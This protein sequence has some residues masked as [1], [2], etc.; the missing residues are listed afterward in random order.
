MTLHRPRLTL[1]LGTVLLGCAAKQTSGGDAGT[2]PS[3]SVSP[4]TLT[5][6]VGAEQSFAATVAGLSNTAVTWSVEEA[7]GGIIS[8]EGVY[9]APGA[10]GT[11]HV[12]ATSVSDATQSATATVAVTNAQAISIVLLPTS[13]ALNPGGTQSFTTEVFGSTNQAVTW[14]VEEG[15]SGGGVT[16]A[17]VYTAPAGAGTF[18]V[19]ATSAKDPTKNAMAVVTV[20]TGTV[21]SVSVSPSSASLGPT[22][23]QAFT[24]TVT[25]TSNNAVTWTVAEGAAGG[26]VSASGLYTSPSAPGVY[27]V[28]ATSVADPSQLASGTIT[29]SALP[30]GA[31]VSGT[32]S[33][34]GTQA[35]RVYLGLFPTGCTS[36]QPVAGTSLAVPG[37]Y[38]LHVGQASGSFSL[39]AFIDTV[40]NQQ[41]AA[42]ADPAGSNTSVML[43]G[44]SLS[45]VNVTLTD[46][47]PS[48]PVA[49]GVPVGFFSNDAALLGWQAPSTPIDHVSVYWT[50]TTASTC[51]TATSQYGAPQTFPAPQQNNGP[52]VFL[53]GLTHGAM[54]CF[55]VAGVAGSLEGP[56]S[57]PLGPVAVTAPTGGSTVS[58]TVS[59]PGLVPSGPLYVAVVQQSATGIPTHLSFVD[60][61]SPSSPQAFTVP[62][63]PD[64]IYGL[65]AFIDMN[66]AGAMVPGV[67]GN[68]SMEYPPQVTVSGGNVSS[69]ML[70][71]P[72]G[73][74]TASAL[75]RHQVGKEADAGVGD[76]YGLQLSLG[77]NLRIP[78]TATLSGGPHLTSLLDVGLSPNGDP[79]SQFNTT[80]FLGP[81]SPSVG[82]TYVFQVTYSDA[83]AAVVSA[84]VSGVIGGVATLLTPPPGGAADS[85]TPTFSWE[86]PGGLSSSD[87]QEILIQPVTG[88]NTIWEVQALPVSKT[89]IAY[90]SDGSA[91]LSSLASMSLYTWSIQISDVNGNTSLAAASFSTP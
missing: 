33:Y 2:P 79:G 37:P 14:S 28:V 16:P 19:V 63:V 23:T 48:T 45:G 26:T 17:G 70:T 4:A 83:T 31:T 32:V 55:M 52:A 81:A 13:V 35:G 12:L 49:P 25:G 80:V 67:V 87:S 53:N 20:Q 74:A 72:A 71:L 91:S 58:G 75:T 47:V 66:H 88:D 89:S 18:H 51:P 77:S 76:L 38:L 15:A 36:C 65:Y 85:G 22:A 50:Q 59:F 64:G 29:V 24:A 73:S 62:G 61:A 7:A 90:N 46:P 78:V 1:A 82:D 5:M 9:T 56:A 10:P 40:G 43:T 84:S 57:A 8:P 69:A 39:T 86:T 3:V 21:A 54:Y 68:T 60:I 44:T 27:H 42:P 41:F 34:A 30:A 11:F 6:S